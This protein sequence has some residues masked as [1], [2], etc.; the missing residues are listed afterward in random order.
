M[1]QF[2]QKIA[3]H[4]ILAFA[5]IP[6]KS[7][8]QVETLPGFGELPLE[9][10]G[11]IKNFSSSDISK[12]SLGIGFECLDRKV[13]EPAE[14]YDKVGSIGVK[15]ARCQTGWARTETQKGVYDFAWLD[16]V[17]DSLLAR[18]VQPWF[19]VG[20]G[21]PIYMPNTDNPTAVGFSPLYYGEECLAAW[22]NYV[23]ALAGHFKGRV[24]MFEIWNEPLDKK[25]W[26]P[27]KP[28]P[29]EYAKLVRLTA[30]VIKEEIP[31]AEIGMC[32]SGTNP[33]AARKFFCE[34]GMGDVADFYSVHPYYLLPE[35][36]YRNE[37]AQIR[38]YIRSAGADTQIMQGE[39][40]F[41]AHIPPQSWYARKTWT[42]SDET[43][44][45]KWMLRRYIT[46]LS[47]GLKMT[48]LFMVTDFNANYK[49]AEGD[50]LNTEAVWGVFEGS[51]GHRPRKIYYAMRNFCAL[52][53][54]QVS[55]S[56]GES[57]SVA[58]NIPPTQKTSRLEESAVESVS[59]VFLRKGKSPLIAYW[60][61]EDLQMRILPD[62]TVK[63]TYY[64]KMPNPVLIDMLNG[65][66]Y[67][68]K[69]QL[70]TLPLA[71]YPLF[72][73]P[74]AAVEDLIEKE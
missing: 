6:I 3:A 38:K 56:D 53:D 32:V 8:A 35:P 49:T 44:Q 11:S 19:N 63:I 23:R 20:Y 10:I 7:A 28:S 73:A 2:L 51:D 54:S 55:P 16:D 15:W 25:F 70:R 14:F 72:I 69:D 36:R 66:V 48:S 45:A 24:K 22:K 13:F 67:K 46:D 12:S 40:G 1:G 52:F 41:P 29:E 61:P 43:L 42:N 62:Y 37:I 71:D 18:G 27:A 33:M 57:I 34:L 17:V 64:G 31:D 47:L 26:R 5:L 74:L 9:Q 68:L 65:K 59:K 50:G 21:N 39:S 30:Q 4:A 58:K 60:L